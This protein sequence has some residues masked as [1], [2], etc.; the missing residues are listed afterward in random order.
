M[1]EYRPICPATDLPPGRGRLVHLDGKEIA[2]FNTNGEFR[3]MED[4]CLHAGGP[5]HEGEVSGTI[6]T[7][8]W[9]QWRFDLRDGSCN[10][11]PKVNLKTYPVRVRDGVIEIG[12][13]PY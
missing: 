2:L 1:S 4:N 3:A 8:P 7:C 12:S 10:L 13:T 5:L 9:H 11:N 6:V